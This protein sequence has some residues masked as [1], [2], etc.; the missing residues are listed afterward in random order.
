MRIDVPEGHL[1]NDWGRSKSVERA[2][3]LRTTKGSVVTAIALFV[4]A[5]P[6]MEASAQNLPPPSRTVFR[7]DLD[8]KVTYS[9]SPCLGACT[10]EVEPT[11]I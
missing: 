10:I 11:P 1:I 7:C 3:K 4:I 2:T 8:G 6:G 9:D 5:A